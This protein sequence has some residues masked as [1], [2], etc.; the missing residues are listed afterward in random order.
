MELTP[1]EQECVAMIERLETV[2]LRK[3]TLRLQAAERAVQRAHEEI[4]AFR[5][6]IEVHRELRAGDHEGDQ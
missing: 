4:Q 5:T 6:T 3:A 2:N 1:F